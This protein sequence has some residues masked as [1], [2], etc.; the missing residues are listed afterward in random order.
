MFVTI[1]ER[2]KTVTGTVHADMEYV[3]TGRGIPEEMVA[4]TKGKVLITSLI[5]KMIFKTFYPMM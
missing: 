5:K 3:W 2:V 4:E 1:S